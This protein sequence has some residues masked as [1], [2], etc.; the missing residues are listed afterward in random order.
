MSVAGYGYRIR[1][2]PSLSSGTSGWAVWTAYRGPGLAPGLGGGGGGGYPTRTNPIFGGGGVA[3][4]N[5]PAGCQGKDEAVTFV[6]TGPQVAAVR[7]GARTIRTFTSSQLPAGD[8]VAVFFRPADS[9]FAVIGWRPGLPINARVRTLQPCQRARSAWIATT[10]VLPLDWSGRVLATAARV[11]DYGFATG[12]SF[13]Q[14][15]S[16]VTPHIHEPPY[17]GRTRP[18]PGICELSQYGFPGLTPEWGSTITRLPTVKD[19]LGEL[20]VS[21]VSTEYYVRGWPMTAAVLLDAGH[22]GGELGSIP[23]A[24]PV[25]GHPSMVD[26]AGASLSARRV[27]NAWLVLQGGSGTAQRLRALRAVEIRKLD[28]RRRAA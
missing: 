19:H 22:P 14:A 9:P 1:V 2:T 27:G 26:F 10:A 6:V 21:C 20:F 24:R 4:W 25:P 11:P 18:R 15:P 23:G 5:W 8:R 13:W 16:A 12:W 17:H 7:I 3:P 28:L